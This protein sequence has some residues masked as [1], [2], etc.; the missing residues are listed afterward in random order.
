MK[1]VQRKNPFKKEKSIA[2]VSQN[3]LAIPIAASKISLELPKDLKFEDWQNIGQHL[4]TM[5][6][7]VMWWVG[8]WWRFGNQAYGE[9]AAQVLDS[10][11]YSFQT[12]ADAGWVAGK[13][14]SSRRRE[15][16][17]WS[18]HR[19]IAGLVPKEQERFLDMAIKENWSRNE[20][21]RAVRDHQLGVVRE[22][23]S[24]AATIHGQF[25]V[26]YADPGWRYQNSGLRG[27]AEEH[28]PT[29]ETEEIKA[30]G[31]ELEPLLTDD[32]VLFLWTTSPLF[33]DAASVMDAW[34]FTYKTHMVWRKDR[35]TYGK[36]AFY[37]YGQHEC[38]L[39]G[40]RGS[41]VPDGEIFT[42]I[43]EA[44]KGEHSRKPDVIY[45]MI[46]KMYTRGPYL[47]LFLRGEERSGWTGFGNQKK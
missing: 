42:S 17:S 27:S 41:F 2:T 36:L 13:I 5:E 14:E 39:I 28:Y 6:G 23:L 21:R 25:P 20:L 15:V 24:L 32:A 8:D 30:M 37:V 3:P 43:I 34:G 35:S 10:K 11:S 47:E 31:K 26:V 16:L 33:L 4:Q 9:R 22:K 40:T 12:F 1:F 46:E 18:H 38:L 29:M 44:D 19:E 45:E 7:S